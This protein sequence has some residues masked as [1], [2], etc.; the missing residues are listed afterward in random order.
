M[1]KKGRKIMVV[2]NIASDCKRLTL[3]QY[4]KDA[5]NHCLYLIQR[6][7]EQDVMCME[8]ETLIETHIGL[9]E[10]LSSENI[11]IYN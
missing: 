1:I 8:P 6:L 11:N 9:V 7:R 2:Q 4:D 5:L 10:I 3:S